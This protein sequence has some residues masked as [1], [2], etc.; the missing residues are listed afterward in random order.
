MSAGKLPVYR[1]F[2]GVAYYAPAAEV[3]GLIR[4]GCAEAITKRQNKQRLYGARLIEGPS[5]PHAGTRYVHCREISESWVDR[6][7]VVH[8]RPRLDQNIRGVYTLK[9]LSH[10]DRA[11][12][13]Q[14][15]TDCLAPFRANADERPR[16]NQ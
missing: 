3:R 14:V 7:G 9:R 8:I 2:G 13:R 12:F 6:F 1:P 16:W 10:L 4:S 11:L 5:R 15:Q